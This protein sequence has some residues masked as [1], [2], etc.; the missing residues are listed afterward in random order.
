MFK[1]VGDRHQRN[2]VGL[3]G[4]FKDA[5]ENGYHTLAVRSI[6]MVHVFP[7]TWICPGSEAEFNLIEAWDFLV[8]HHRGDSSK[9]MRLLQEPVESESGRKRTEDREE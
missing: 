6:T 2:A 4:S 1:R 3:P 8:K 7:S 9:E 5:L